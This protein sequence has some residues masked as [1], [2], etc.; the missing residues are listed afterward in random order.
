MHTVSQLIDA[1]ADI[2]PQK[3]AVIDRGGVWTYAELAAE[4]RRLAGGLLKLG[5]GFGGLSLFPPSRRPPARAG[6]QPPR[7]APPG[8]PAG[9]A[10]PTLHCSSG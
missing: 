3:I 4:S 9:T 10:R 2:G 6:P 5:I 1:R 7:P 8:P